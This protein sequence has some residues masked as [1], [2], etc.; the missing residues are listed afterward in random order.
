MNYWIIEKDLP[1]P[2]NKQLA[3]AYLEA[4]KNGGSK[5]FTI[6]MHKMILG[7]FLMNLT[8]DIELLVKADVRNWLKTQYH[9]KPSIAI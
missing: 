5:Y 4:L 8:F 6:C 7:L 1:N 3:N 9:S 2:Q